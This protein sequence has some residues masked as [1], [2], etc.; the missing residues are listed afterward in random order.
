MDRR[1]QMMAL[2]E[3]IRRFALALKGG[4]IATLESLLSLGYKHTDRL[5]KLWVRD[6]WLAQIRPEARSPNAMDF[7]HL[8]ATLMGDLGIVT[9]IK[10]LRIVGTSEDKQEPPTA[11]TQL[12]IWRDERW[13]RELFQETPIVELDAL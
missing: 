7:G 10:H 9:G 12:W 1:D 3:A 5:G 2:N 13:L 4:D 11:Y 6:E 8:T